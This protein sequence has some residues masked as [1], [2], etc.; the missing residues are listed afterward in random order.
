MTGLSSW[1]KYV[2][3]VV[4]GVSLS[5]GF[6]QLIPKKESQP[7]VLLPLMTEAS[8]SNSSGKDTAG[9][10]MSTLQDIWIWIWERK[11]SRDDKLW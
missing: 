8:E 7:K 6:N 2:L 9:E 5:L 1:H 4:R 10:T 11:S 3:T